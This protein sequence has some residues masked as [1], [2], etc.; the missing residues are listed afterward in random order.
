MPPLKCACGGTA[1]TVDLPDGID[2]ASADWVTSA[3]SKSQEAIRGGA[4]KG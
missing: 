2:P 1:C 4:R 3:R